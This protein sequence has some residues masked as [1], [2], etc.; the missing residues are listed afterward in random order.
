M[1][2]VESGTASIG[3]LL[4]GASF[5][6]IEDFI[7]SVSD[8]VEDGELAA[9]LLTLTDNIKDYKFGIDMTLHA[10]QLRIISSVHDDAS[11]GNSNFL[12]DAGETINLNVTVKNVGSSA[13]SGQCQHHSLRVMALSFRDGASVRSYSIPAKRRW[14]ALRV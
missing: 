11:A 10:P 8:M 7:F 6:I 12:P 4:P 3:N 9:L 14:F 5:T 13:A 1:I 2:T